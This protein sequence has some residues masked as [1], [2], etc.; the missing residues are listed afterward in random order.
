MRI[1]IFVLLIIYG[2]APQG[3]YS[4]ARNEKDV[5]QSYLKFKGNQQDLKHFNKDFKESKKIIDVGTFLLPESY[6]ILYDV[7][8]KKTY[9]IERN[10]SWKEPKYYDSILHNKK[11]RWYQ[12]LEFVLQYVLDDQIEELKSI[13]QNA[14]NVYNANIVIRI[15]DLE[16]K[17]YKEYQINSF[18]VYKGKP[19]MNFDEFWEIDWSKL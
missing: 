2:C 6:S 16:A 15:L 14:Y 11:K 19:I 3:F 1:L 12:N 17:S 5:F 8:G 18:E 9:Y 7:T 4:K 10:T 13:S